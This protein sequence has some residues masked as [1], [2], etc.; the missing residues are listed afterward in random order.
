[1]EVVWNY[2]DQ[3]YSVK[4]KIGTQSIV[5]KAQLDDLKLSEDSEDENTEKAAAD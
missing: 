3:E 5:M 2:D 1:M 4:E